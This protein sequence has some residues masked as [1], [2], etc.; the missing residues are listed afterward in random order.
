MKSAFYSIIIPTYNSGKTIAACIESL[1]NQSFQNYEVLIIDGASTDETQILVEKFRV[2]NNQMQWHSEKDKGIYDAMNKGI[3]KANGEW[4]LFLGSDDCLHDKYVLE[5]IFKAEKENYNVIYGNAKIIGDAAWA[6]NGVIYDGEFNLKKLLKKNICQQAIFYNKKCFEGDS[7]FNTNY[8]ICAD[9]D[10]N[11]RCWAKKE[12]LYID[13]IISN[14]Y[15]GGASTHTNAN[16]EFYDDFN[17]NIKQYFGIV[18]NQVSSKETTISKIPGTAQK[19]KNKIK[20]WL[21]H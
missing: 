15:G 5:N 8:E 9:W 10:F 18:L 11:F 7:N 16:R 21:R 6:K 17:K 20:H 19:I 1:L 12:F 3:K 4:L 2:N 13:L 14:F